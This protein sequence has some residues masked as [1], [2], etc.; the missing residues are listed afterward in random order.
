MQFTGSPSSG[1]E[2]EEDDD[3][4]S[5]AVRFHVGSLVTFVDESNGDFGLGRNVLLVVVET[6]QVDTS[7][8]A[9]F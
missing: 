8:S 9:S 2:G 1:H 5:D 7:V 3:Y 4:E 6:A